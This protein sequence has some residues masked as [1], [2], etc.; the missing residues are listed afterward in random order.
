MRRCRSFRDGLRPGRQWPRRGRRRRGRR[1]G[2]PGRA[3]ACAGRRR[4]RRA[5]A[6]ARDAAA[7][8]REPDRRA[9]GAA[10]A[11]EGRTGSRTPQPP[12][13]TRGRARSRPRRAPA[14]RRLRGRGLEG[15]QPR[16]RGD[17]Q[18]PRR[19]RQDAREAASRRSSMH[20]AELSLPGRR[21]SVRARRLLPHV[22]R[23]RRSASRKASSPSRRC[24]GGLL[25]KVGKMRD[26]F[27]KVNAL[28]KHV[29]A[30]GRPAARHG[31]PRRRRR[32]PRRR[33]ASRS[34]RLIPNPWLF[35][36]AT[37][38]VYR[39]GSEVFKAPTRGRPR[40]RRPPARLPRP[41][42]VHQPRPR[43][44]D[45]VRPQRRRP[46]TP[47]RASS[48]STPRCRW[49]PLRR[50]I[51]TRFLAPRRARLEPA[52]AS[53]TGAQR[54]LRRL[55]LPRV[56]V[57]RAAGSPALRYDRSERA[58]DAGAPRQGRLG[59]PDLLAERVQPGPRPVP[60]HRLRRGRDG[61]R[62]PVPVPVRD[63]RARRASVLSRRG[64]HERLACSLVAARRAARGA[65]APRAGPLNVVTTTEDLAVARAR[66]RRRQGQGRGHRAG[67]TRIRTSSRPSRAS[68]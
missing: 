16:H 20:E 26:A 10:P 49:R 19:G 6:R 17:R 52:R 30:V 33:R 66:G 27:G 46:R 31:E 51:Y 39:G 57:R 36:E 38:Q 22:R 25:M 48:A 60:P 37:G 53:P 65:A 7:G 54:R 55:R 14:P 21:R 2:R 5:A 24:P 63:R 40:L 67:A 58:D 47:R 1:R 15:L 64:P 62:V 35:L 41:H 9:R 34:P 42:R 45:R 44:L 43:R 3:A 18:L 32:R 56:P 11:L 12:R 13:R 29:A 68:S 59:R 61:Q 8:L 4:A 23:R 28:H 50:S